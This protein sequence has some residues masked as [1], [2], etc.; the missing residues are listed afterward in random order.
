MLV[1]LSYG[2]DNCPCRVATGHG[3]MKKGSNEFSGFQTYSVLCDINNSMY[4]QWSEITNLAMQK[5]FFLPAHE[6]FGGSVLFSLVETF[7]SS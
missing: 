3:N 1:M 2:Y 6:R 7:P 5:F 4:L